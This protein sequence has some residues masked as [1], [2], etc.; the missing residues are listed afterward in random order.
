MLLPD[1]SSIAA[2]PFGST[3]AYFINWVTTYQ[4]TRPVTTLR[5]NF[6][7]SHK[8]PAC[9]LTSQFY[10]FITDTIVCTWAGRTVCFLEEYSRLVDI[11]IFKFCKKRCKIRNKTQHSAINWY[12]FLIVYASIRFGVQLTK[13]MFYLMCT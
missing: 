1:T 6:D 4:Y 8:N 10:N 2:F 11:F 13:Y 7:A 5:I 3:Y 12:L 9:S